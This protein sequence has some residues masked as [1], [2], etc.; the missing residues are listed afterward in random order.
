[1]A[2]AVADDVRRVG[3]GRAM[4]AASIGWAQEHGICHLRASMRWGHS[5]VI[6]LV[7]TAGYPVAW[8]TPTGGGLEALIDVGAAMSTAA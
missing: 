8:S 3:L 6:S 1:M 7:R 5:P 4:L 2:V